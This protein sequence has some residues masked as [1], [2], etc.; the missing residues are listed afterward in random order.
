[1]HQN[2]DVRE[3]CDAA[4]PHFNP[5][6]T[7]HGGLGDKNRHAGDF[8]NIYSVG[9]FFSEDFQPLTLSLGGVVV[10]DAVTFSIAPSWFE[11]GG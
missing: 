10:C 3:G 9:Q 8:G 4:G 11:F 1:M 7:R 6:R 5:Y 2:G